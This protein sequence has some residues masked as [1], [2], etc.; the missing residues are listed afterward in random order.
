MRRSIRG[1]CAESAEHIHLGPEHISQ[2]KY[3]AVPDFQCTVEQHQP[4]QTVG[5]TLSQHNAVTYIPFFGVQR[6]NAAPFEVLFTPERDKV[7][8]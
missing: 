5:I 1:E 6:D 8:A 4:H 2:Q 7:P 3:P